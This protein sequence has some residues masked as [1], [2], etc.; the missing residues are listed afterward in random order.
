MCTFYV[1]D[2]VKN[3]NQIAATAFT[4]TYMQKR[5]IELVYPEPDETRTAEDVI[6]HIKDGLNKLGA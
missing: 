4:G 3:I 2:A 5:L 6:N 1:A